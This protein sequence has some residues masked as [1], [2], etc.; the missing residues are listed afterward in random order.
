[1]LSAAD[2]ELLCRVG[3][4]TP[5]GEYLRRFWTPVLRSSDLPDQDGDTREVRIL[6]E[7]LIAFRDTAGRVGLI[8][9]RCPHRQAP[10][11]YAR[12]EEGGLRCIYHGWKYDVSGQ[13]VD[14][15][16]EPKESNFKAKVQARTYPVQEWAD[17]IWAYLG[18]AH[19]QP[20]LPQLEWGR[21]PSSHRTMVLYQQDCNFIQ[22]IEGDLDSS[23]LGFLH[24]DGRAQ[25][26]ALLRDMA[27]SWLV[28][29]TEYGVMA[30]G[31]RP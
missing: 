28:A 16:S 11:Y 27:P 8:Q 12:N 4:G 10:L 21:V 19:L 30:G 7:D 5:M 23:H 15:P 25:G 9:P 29:L 14:M 26:D 1:M 18:P 3:A 20:A 31:R 2:N 17:I 13:C 24:R 22:A 6:G